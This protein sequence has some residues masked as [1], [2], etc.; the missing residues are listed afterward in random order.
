MATI[1]ET[2]IEQGWNEGFHRAVLDSIEI[3][4]ELK[5]GQSGLM[6]LPEIQQLEDVNLL[7][8]IQNSMRTA[9]SVEEVRSLYQSQQ[10]TVH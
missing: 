8:Q 4:L 3:L 6:L 1:A 5:F 7:Q 2:L 9:N 10:Q